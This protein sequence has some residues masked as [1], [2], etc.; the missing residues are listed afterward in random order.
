MKQLWQIILVLLVSAAVYGQDLQIRAYVSQNTVGPDDQFTYSVEISGQST[1]LP[2]PKF[3]DLKDFYILSGPNQSTNIQWVNGSMSS[4]K[5]YTF[6]LQPRRKGSFTIGPATLNSNGRTIRSAPLTVNVSGSVMKKAPKPRTRQPGAQTSPD[7]SSQNLFIKTNIS[8]RNVYLGEQV[9]V[10]YKLYF[11][12]NVRGFDF[13]KIP[14]YAGF[15]TEEFEIPG[16]P[17]IENEVINGLNYNVATIRKIALFPTQSGDFRLEPIQVT[18]DAEVRAKRRRSLF[19]SFFDDPFGRTIQKTV[20]SKP[21]TIHVKELPEMGKPADFSGAVGNYSLKVSTDKSS[22]NVNEAI[23]LKVQIQGNGNI[24]LAQLPQPQIP[25]DIEKYEPKISSNINKKGNIISGF[26]RAEYILVPR[27]EGLYQIK[28]V[29]FTY[30]NP[31]TKS[32]KTI[33]SGPI[34]LKIGKGSTSRIVTRQPGAGLSRQEVSLLG[35]DIRFIKEY[36]EFQQRGYRPYYSLTFWGSLTL[37]LLLFLGF[38]FYNDQQARLSRDERLARSRRAGRIAARQLAAAKNKIT[39]ASADQAEFYKAVSN[40][41]QG[42]VRDRLQ[43]E[44]TDFSQQNVR[45]VLQQKGIA[46][47]EINEYLAVLEESDFRQFANISA[48]ADQRQAFYERA[49]SILTRFEK[50]IR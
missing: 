45:R 46:D 24:K 1:S 30:F 37:G 42:F 15:W 19:D 5:T 20:I 6:Y 16:R 11:R 7:I 32:Y 48:S 25:K 2:E 40:A 31:R 35:Q 27:I 17:V 41:L 13:K 39:S 14:A 9:L 29:R 50:W 23:S 28:P 8:R 4:S 18:L 12:V 36:T 21:L 44:L 34:D 22:V 49:R 43:I 10:E 26:K 3:P 38:I 33:T 47:D